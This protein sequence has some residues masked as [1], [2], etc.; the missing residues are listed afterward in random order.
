MNDRN[1]PTKLTFSLNGERYYI[2]CES[3]DDADNLYWEVFKYVGIKNMRTNQTSKPKAIKIDRMNW[4]KWMEEHTE[5]I[6]P[7]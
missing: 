3:L 4:Q 1:K 7:I 2:E 6:C 5:R